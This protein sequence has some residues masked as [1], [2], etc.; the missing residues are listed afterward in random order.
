MLTVATHWRGAS[1]LH[2]ALRSTS[3]LT[4][5]VGGALLP[6]LAAMPSPFY[7]FDEVDAALDT[8]NAARVAEYMAMGGLCINTQPNRSTQSPSAFT[9]D[10]RATEIN[11]FAALPGTAANEAGAEMWAAAA[12]VG[13]CF[14]GARPEGSLQAYIQQQHLQQRQKQ[15]HVTRGQGPQFIVVSHRPQVF[16]RA[17]C[18]VGVYSKEGGSSSAVLA[19]L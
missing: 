4:S 12:G 7:F 9:P 19:R 14:Q 5:I 8:M 11:K 13:D 17:S 6:F 2:M 15:A 1:F 3:G 16:E 18:L 10:T